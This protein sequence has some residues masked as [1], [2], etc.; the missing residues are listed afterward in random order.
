MHYSLWKTIAEEGPS[1]IK[2]HEMNISYLEWAEIEELY[3]DLVGEDESGYDIYK[4]PS[5]IKDNPFERQLDKETGLPDYWFRLKVPRVD[6]ELMGAIDPKSLI[7]SMASND[8]DG[9]I[10]TCGCGEPGCS[11]FWEEFCHVSEKM[12][13][14]TVNQYEVY[15]ELFFERKNYERYA[16]KLDVS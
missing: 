14:W 5:L 12:V 10:L 15:V 16:F 7:R 3:P 9:Y 2:K 4:S 11:G 13:H 1:A 6:F 8:Y